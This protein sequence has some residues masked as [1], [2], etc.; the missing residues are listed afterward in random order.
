MTSL[1]GIHVIQL[2]FLNKYLYLIIYRSVKI[3]LGR[4]CNIDEAYYELGSINTTVC[5]EKI[6]NLL[7]A[8]K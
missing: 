4:R 3:N 6:K 5:Y 7:I 2:T 1:V 8:L